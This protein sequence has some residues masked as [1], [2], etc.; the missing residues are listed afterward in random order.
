MTINNLNITKSLENLEALL[1]EEKAIS[2][3]LKAAIELLVVIVHLLINKLGINSS[4]SSK[5]PSQDPNRTK[6]PK[7]QKSGKRPGGQKGHNGETL[8]PYSDPDEVIDIPIDRKTLPDGNYHSAGFESKQTVDI[9]VT[10]HVTEYR[11]EVLENEKGDRFVAPFPGEITNP[12]QYGNNLKAHAV[13]LSQFQLIPYDRIVDYF[14]D[15]AGIPISKGSIFN[16]NQKAFDM[17]GAYDEYVKRKLKEDDILN[18]DETSIN[19]N[20][21]K[22]WLHSASNEKWTH[23][24]PHP[25]RGS[26]A[27]NEIG[28][29]PAFSGTLVHD[30]WKPYYKYDCVHALCNAHHLRELERAWEQDGQAWAKKMQDLLLE[31]RNAVDLNGGSVSFIKAQLFEF[32]YLKILKNGE[33]ECPLPIPPP[34]KKPGRIKKS[35]SR[36]L[37]E[38]LL[39]FKEDVL[40]FLR[41]KDV[42]FTNNRGENDLRMT[43]V[44]QK[45]SGCFRSYEGAKIFCRIRGYLSTCRKNKVSASQALTSLFNGSLPDFITDDM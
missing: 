41:N 9:L 38:R 37:L 6:L 31:M 5:P 15:Q 20:G 22:N 32:K 24:F 2:P 29:I 11:A 7:K 14:S 12:V 35:K 21:T 28:I 45:I 43:K 30:H 25:K 26:E 36:N 17:L 33:K 13:Y 10:R 16:F 1:N 18:V 4:N 3:A 23:F 44:Q 8:V 42:P 40:R 27:M 19:V 34:E 39:N